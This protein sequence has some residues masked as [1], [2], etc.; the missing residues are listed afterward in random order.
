MSVQRLGEREWGGGEK[1]VL[2]KYLL[3]RKLD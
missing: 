1:E 3:E 2:I